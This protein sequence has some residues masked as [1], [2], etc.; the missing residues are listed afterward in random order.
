M[1][2]FTFPLVKM[3]NGL[4]IFNRQLDQLIERYHTHGVVV[5]I[6]CGKC[7]RTGPMDGT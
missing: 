7:A 4:E 5:A 1:L 3:E 6:M 2:E